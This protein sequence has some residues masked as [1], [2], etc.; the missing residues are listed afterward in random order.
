M[1]MST[2]YAGRTPPHTPPGIYAMAMQSR[3]VL[4]PASAMSPSRRADYASLAYTG[5]ELTA[6]YIPLL[7]VMCI[8]HDACTLA[9]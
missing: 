6:H 4:S 5:S 1:D 2:A 3:P 7:Y 8:L 9:E